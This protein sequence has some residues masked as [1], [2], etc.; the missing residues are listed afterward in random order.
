[1][2][3]DYLAN[4]MDA[5]SGAAQVQE[6]MEDASR[7]ERLEMLQMQ[8]NL[9]AVAKAAALIDIASSLRAMRGDR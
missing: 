1:M 6:A 8:A 7:S 3:I 9:T 5:L 4:A 2:P